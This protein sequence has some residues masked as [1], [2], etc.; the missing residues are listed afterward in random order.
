MSFFDY[1]LTPILIIVHLAVAY[2]IPVVATLRSRNNGQRWIIHW[3]VF[4]LL[5]LT[6]FRVW[7]F[8]FGGAVYWL[9]IVFSELGLLFALAQHVASVL[10]RLM[11]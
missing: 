8:L 9:L 1:I 4:I 11:P 3:I 2:V 10:F 6:V 7:D 5:R